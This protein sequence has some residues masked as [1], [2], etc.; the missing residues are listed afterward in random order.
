MQEVFIPG[1]L[2][3][4]LSKAYLNGQKQIG[5]GVFWDDKPA[6]AMDLWFMSLPRDIDPEWFVGCRK[7]WLLFNERSE[8][9]VA[10]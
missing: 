8:P 1:I 7:T 6:T 3:I 2:L 5:T 4:K 9:G 10:R